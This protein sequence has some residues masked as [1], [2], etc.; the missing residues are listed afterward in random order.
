VKILVASRDN[1]VEAMRRALDGEVVAGLVPGSRPERHLASFRPGEPV[2]ERGAAVIA[3][4]SGSTGD[5]KSVVLSRDAIAASVTATH[6]RLGG[7]GQWVCPLP[8]EHVAGMMTIAR[9][10]LGG[11][12]VRFARGDL[13]DV[14]VPGDRAYVSIVPAQLHR[15]LADEVLLARL[16]CYAAV[17]VGGSPIPAGLAERAR[18]RGVAVVT[19]Y[20]M[21]ET[22]GGCVYDG[23]PLDGM[24]VSVEPDERIVLAGPAVFSGY[25]LDPERTRAVL[26][27]DR[28][29]T[30]DRGGFVNGRLHVFG[31]FDDVIITGGVNVDLA[32]AQRVA[33]AIWG[34]A[35][36]ARVV[37]LAIDDERWGARIV[38]VT[39]APLT[40]EEIQASLR[41]HVE[42]AAL[43]RETRRLALPPVALAG[44]IDRAAMR[45]I[46]EEC[47]GD[48]C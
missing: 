16:A 37:L 40:V 38:A 1:A 43:P 18:E 32:A 33:D 20:G 5:P 48:G 29:R 2:V 17:L 22:C 46:W 19:T 35:Q 31:R 23:V 8:V 7:A 26:C 3:A 45:A 34:V 12:G 24:R 9:G 47:D 27:G 11:C 4:T 42:V 36:A 6:A 13:T 15:A 44:K 39:Q 28:V 21:S 41:P 10:L 30:Q 25:R 14:P